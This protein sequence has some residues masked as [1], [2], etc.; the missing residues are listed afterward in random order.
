MLI[1]PK[2][3]NYILGNPPFVGPRFMTSEQKDDLL[4]LFSGV[5]GNGDLDFVSCWFLKASNFI[6]KSNTRVAF[7]S[8]N[9][10][11]QG[12]QVGILWNELIN[13]KK[14]DIFLHIELLNG[15]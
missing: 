8:T 3:C 11:T 13:N 1:D 15:L 5:K 9:S 12:E 10:I 2:E 6:D 7:V 14:I 4:Y